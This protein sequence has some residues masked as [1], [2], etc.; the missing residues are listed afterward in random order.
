VS[1]KKSM[2][3]VLQQCVSAVVPAQHLH[4]I[5]ST[6]VSCDDVACAV[7]RDAAGTS[8]SS[9]NSLKLCIFMPCSSGHTNW[10]PKFCQARLK[11]SSSNSEGVLQGPSPS[12]SG[13]GI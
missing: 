8:Y 10:M 4:S 13:G 7:K 5:N 3:E 12:M 6:R 11:A 1:L 9:S 2:D